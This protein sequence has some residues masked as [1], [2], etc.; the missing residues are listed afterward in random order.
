MAKI[1]KILI[2]NRAEI[3]VRV[4]ST[5]REMGIKTV[6]LFSEHDKNL[7]HAYLADESYFLEGETLAQTYLNQEKILQIAK[8][9]KAD[10]IHPGYGF[11]SENAGF[12]DKVK[13]AGL[14]FIGPSSESIIV[15]GDKKGS[16]ETLEKIGTPLIPGYHGE[17]QDADFLLLEAKKIGFPVLIKASAGGGGK[18]MRIVHQESEFHEALSSA[19]NEAQKAFG[20]DIV[21]IEKYLEG[22]RH[23]EVQV[24]GD[25]HGNVVHFFERECSVQRRYQKIVEESP[26]PALSEDLREKIC[27]TAVEIAQGINYVGA[28]TVE[29]ILDKHKN[30]YFLEMNTRLQVEHPV[31][32]MLTGVDLVRLQILVAQG[33]KLPFKQDEIRSRGHALEVRIYAEDPDNNFLPVIGTV[34]K[35]GNSLST[36]VRLDTGI[37]NGTAITPFYDPMIAKLLTYGEIREVNIERML[38]AIDDHPFLGLTTNRDYLKR[39]LKNSFFRKGDYT[40]HFIQENKLEK[41]KIDDEKKAAA[42]A[43][44]IL[45]SSSSTSVSKQSVVSVWDKIGSFRNI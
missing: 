14:I 39:V 38:S 19:K 22:P 30:F 41:E 4:I 18:G 45:L 28:G 40:T 11:L 35:I 7:P 1:K 27:Q 15:M 44:A 32:E 9:T 36:H 25:E 37:E 24:F 26:S 33:E 31:T 34:Y 16:K 6:T 17:K 13:K 10:A 5:A 3:A 43:A 42:L 23:I 8:E 20:N 29:M 21:L 2:A 12:A